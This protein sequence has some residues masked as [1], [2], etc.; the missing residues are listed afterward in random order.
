MTLL[1]ALNAGLEAVLGFVVGVSD[2]GWRWAVNGGLSR[3]WIAVKRRVS[4]QCDFQVTDKAREI[5]RSGW[6]GKN[7]HNLC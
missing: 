2:H 6:A 5:W 4:M 1:I 7:L 3:R